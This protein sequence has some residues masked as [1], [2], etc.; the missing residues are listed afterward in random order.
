MRV[1]A[2]TVCL[3]SSWL[4][5]SLAQE[6]G[7]SFEDVLKGMLSA[8]GDLTQALSEVKDEDSAKAA[9]PAL[10]KGAARFTELRKKAETMKPPSPE[11]KDKLEK[12]YRPKIFEAHKKLLTEIGRVRSV[13]G[14]RE[15]L[16][17][18]STVLNPDQKK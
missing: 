16:R 7:A 18:L 9:V 5:A 12:E 13:P 10:K 6:N 1:S 4:A 15:A 14:G 2:A 17:E 8:L 3:A 11:E